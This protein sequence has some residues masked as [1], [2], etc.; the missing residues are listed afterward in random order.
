M[1][2]S[3][4]DWYQ[5][6]RVRIGS[7]PTPLRSCEGAW[8]AAELVPHLSHPLVAQL[9]A[10]VER[11]LLR[12]SL[13]RYL[14]AT[15]VLELQ[16]VNEVVAEVARGAWDFETSAGG[17]LEARKIY[18][19]EGYHA[20]LAG[21]LLSQVGA[22]DDETPA[23]FERLSALQAAHARTDEEARLIRFLFTVVT[24]TAITQTLVNLTR[25]LTVRPAVRE[26][27]AEHAKDEARH[28]GFFSALFADCWRWLSPT[29][30]SRFG[31]LLP[32]L[33]RAFL[34]PDAAA[35]DADLRRVGLTASQGAQVLG[36]SGPD[37]GEAVRRGARPVLACFRRGGA[38]GAQSHEAFDGLI[39]GH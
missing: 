38:L 6:A 10:E 9:G 3:R 37:L 17:R 2:P 19:D 23:F 7:R 4:S 24:E 11:E 13:V 16:V 39:G 31:A 30:R 1:N 29:E 36:E 35:I 5:S 8:F 18:C 12:R 34:S 22:A 21:E 32:Q 15:D 25:N 27:A 28:A 14:H 33:V 26:F 20:V